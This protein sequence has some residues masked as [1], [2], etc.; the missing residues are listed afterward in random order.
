[1]GDVQVAFE[2]FTHCSMQRS[3]YFFHFFFAL[4]DFQC[5]LASFDSTFICVFEKILRLGF[6]ECLEVFLLGAVGASSLGPFSFQAHLKW[7][8]DL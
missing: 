7:V 6:L 5:L 8:C 2:I 4:P 3:Y 1:M